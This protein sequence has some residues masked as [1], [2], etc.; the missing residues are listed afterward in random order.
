MNEG[1]EVERT[2]PISPKRNPQLYSMINCKVLKLR[3]PNHVTLSISKQRRRG[4]CRMASVRMASLPSSSLPLQSVVVPSFS[5]SCR[6]G[7]LSFPCA[8]AAEAVESSG[9]ASKR[10]KVTAIC[11]RFSNVT[12]IC[13]CCSFAPSSAVLALADR[14]CCFVVPIS[15]F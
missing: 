3:R 2:M 6:N 7:T 12:I 10:R 4:C 9:R 13:C 15:R 1:A 11:R 8:A 5:L 14:R